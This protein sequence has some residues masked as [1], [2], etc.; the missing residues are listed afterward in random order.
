MSPTQSIRLQ[1]RLRRE[2]IAAALLDDQRTY[3]QIGAEF[4]GLCRE[5][6]R[7]IARQYGITRKG[8]AHAS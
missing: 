4:G 7:Q 2:A 6:V 5:R 3:Q 8:K 1:Q